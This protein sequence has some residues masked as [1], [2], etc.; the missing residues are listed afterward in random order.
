MT[1]ILIALLRS[2]VLGLVLIAIY[3]IWLVVTILTYPFGR[4]KRRIC[5]S[6]FQS[7]AKIVAKII[8]MRLKVQGQPP[9]GPFLLVSNH[10]SYVDIIAFASQSNCTFI[11]KREVS[12]WP[13]IGMLARSMN[14]IFIDRTNRNDIPRVLF[15]TKRAL[16]DGQNVVLFAEGT[17]SAGETVLPFKSALL[18]IAAQLNCPVSYA[19]LSYHSPVDNAPAHLS[20]CWWGDMTFLKHLFNLLRLP[21]FNATLVFGETSVTTNDRKTLARELWTQVHRQFTTVI[22]QSMR[23]EQ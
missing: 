8:G 7:S 21:F 10:L 23:T 5:N 16:L 9:K 20:V 4:A 3:A 13:L 17:S 15:A 14:T 22:Q 1:R 2:A 11:A 6:L 18:E 19:S 12:T